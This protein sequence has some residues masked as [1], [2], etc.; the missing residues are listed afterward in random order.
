MATN[1]PTITERINKIA[2]DVEKKANTP[3][4]EH[5]K[6]VGEALDR[7]AEAVEKL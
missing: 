2:D 5:A 6:T 7:L 4:T 3:K 1:N